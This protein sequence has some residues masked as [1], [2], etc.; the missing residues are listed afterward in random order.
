MYMALSDTT[1]RQARASG[2]EMRTMS[3]PLLVRGNVICNNTRRIVYNTADRCDPRLEK[4]GARSRRE[5][6]KQ[7][8]QSTNEHDE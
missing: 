2:T 6:K 7:M 3:S 5:Q 1:I 8:R 4:D